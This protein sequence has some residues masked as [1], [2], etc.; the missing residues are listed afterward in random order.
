MKEYFCSFYGELRGMGGTKSGV[1][2]YCCSLGKM[3]EE[4]FDR[5]ILQTTD[6]VK[7]YSVMFMGN[8]VFHSDIKEE[9][10]CALKHFEKD[11][12]KYNDS[13][14]SEM[15]QIQNVARSIRASRPP[16]PNTAPLHVAD[17]PR[18]TQA[19]TGVGVPDIIDSYQADIEDP[20]GTPVN[21]HDA[22]VLQVLER[23]EK[24][25]PTGE[26]IENQTK[27]LTAAINNNTRNQERAVFNGSFRA[28]ARF[29]DGTEFTETDVEMIHRLRCDNVPWND[30][31]REVYR[32]EED[33]EIQE[34]NLPFYVNALQQRYKR[35]YPDPAT[36]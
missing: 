19:A 9:Q 33:D 23:I 10:D 13:I 20:D 14:G 4:E 8:F 36:K 11:I 1:Q 12:T 31:G 24:K 30:V 27:E 21:V 7:Y 35:A 5:F 3:T 15:V 16:A 17:Y 6:M 28:Q 29:A 26:T 32:K 34:R 25:I 22:K 2:L 18:M